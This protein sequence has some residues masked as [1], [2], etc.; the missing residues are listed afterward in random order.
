MPNGFIRSDQADIYV[1][2]NGVQYGGSWATYAGGVLSAAD[3]KT[4]S[5]GMGSEVSLGG[6]ASRSDATVTIQLDATV[7][8]WHPTIES[9]TGRGDVAAKVTIQYLNPDKSVMTGA[10][11][12]RVGTVKEA[13]L[14]DST[15]ENGDAVFYTL[16]L[17]L[18]ELPA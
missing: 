9:Y 11:F 15:Y 7:C 3:A 12:S 17:S 1:T 13:A 18:D 5:G 2:I 10:Q 14:P 16:V 4:R 8:G 6:P